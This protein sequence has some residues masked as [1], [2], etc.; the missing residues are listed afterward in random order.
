MLT[1]TGRLENVFKSPDGVGKDGVHYQGA[2]KV[3]ILAAEALRNG[4][5]RLS[6]FDLRTDDPGAFE[7]LTGEEVKVEVRAYA[8]GQQVGFSHLAGTPVD[9]AKTAKT[10]GPKA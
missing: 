7:G 1:L 10:A 6:V 5:E 8:F 4:Q 9:C 3:Q 2:F